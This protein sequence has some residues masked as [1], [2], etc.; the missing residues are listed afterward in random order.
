MR[1]PNF[2]EPECS[3]GYTDEQIREI[4]G[5]RYD[6]F[7]KWMSGQTMML[8]TGER[9][10]YNTKEYERDCDTPHGPVTYSHDAKR[11]FNKIQVWD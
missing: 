4:M 2:P 3:G 7:N 11:F 6:E 5:D 1:Q 9:Y 10:N 8:C